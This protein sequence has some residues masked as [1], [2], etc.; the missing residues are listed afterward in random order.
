MARRRLWQSLAPWLPTLGWTAVLFMLSAQSS[1]ISPRR[2]GLSDTAAHFLVYTVLGVAL[3]WGQ[4]RS[5]PRVPHWLT[6]GFGAVYG[7]SDELHQAFVPGRTPAVSDFVAD[8][9]GV[10]AGY[11]AVFLVARAMRWRSARTEAA[12]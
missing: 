11:L 10:V 5:R 8:C 1:P 12:S 6:L 4:R 7:A 9:A 2:F 3:A